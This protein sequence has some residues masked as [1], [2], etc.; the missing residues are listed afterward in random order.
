[1]PIKI[2]ERFIGVCYFCREREI[3]FYILKPGCK[4]TGYL[5]GILLAEAL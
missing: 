1:M 4:N 3:E 2:Y 5:N